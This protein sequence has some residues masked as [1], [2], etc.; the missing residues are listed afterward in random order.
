MDFASVSTA[1]TSLQ[2]A[3][4]ALNSILVVRDFNAMAPKIAAINDQLLK[5]QDGLFTC[6]TKVSELQ[7]KLLA[8]TAE[9]TELKKKAEQHARYSLFQLSPGIFVYGLK[10]REDGHEFA[11]KGNA[12]PMHYLC[13]SCLDNRGHR[14]ILQAR[15]KGWVCIGCNAGFYPQEGATGPK[16]GVVHP[17]IS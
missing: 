4:E 3:K 2:L 10:Q 1:F 7:E 14:V 12:E 17:G 5:A 11:V 16:R 9:L 6:S 8:A 13:Q 15:G